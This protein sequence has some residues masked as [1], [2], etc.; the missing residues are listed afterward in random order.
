VNEFKRTHEA[1][2]SS[3]LNRDME[4]SAFGQILLA[5]VRGL[6]EALAA[7]LVDDEGETVDYA[8]TLSAYDLRVV[9]AEGQ[10]LMRFKS[11]GSAVRQISTYA[12]SRMFLVRALFEGY[13][14]VVVA[15]TSAT[16]SFPSLSLDAADH[17]LCAEAG[18]PSKATW[19]SVAVESDHEGNPTG[20]FGQ[21]IVVESSHRMPSQNTV[22]FRVK[23]T[24]CAL[25]EIVAEL[26]A[27][28]V[29][30]RWF[31]RIL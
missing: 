4:L 9:G 12:G 20:V 15:R 29:S 13:V 10:L 16:P 7:V 18:Y 3:V 6:P 27:K 5:L 22:L 23:D 26:D 8:G 28:G 17:D 19:R 11:A 30:K 1:I 31:T 25:H 21:R 24:S 14:L 2:A